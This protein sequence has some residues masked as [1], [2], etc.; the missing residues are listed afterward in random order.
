MTRAPQSRLA[1]ST[2]SKL[3]AEKL[4]LAFPNR[5]CALE[6]NYAPDKQRRRSRVQPE[7]VDNFDFFAH[8]EGKRALGTETKPGMRGQIVRPIARIAAGLAESEATV[9][10][11]KLA[12]TS[13][14]TAFV[15][16]AWQTGHP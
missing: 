1:V 2:S 16:S 13:M 8:A 3:A 4:L 9:N 15:Q 14:L 6:P 5:N 10:S 11:C 7:L 12:R